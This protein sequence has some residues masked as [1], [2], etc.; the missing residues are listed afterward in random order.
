MPYSTRKSSSPQIVKSFFP[1]LF[2]H[3]NRSDRQER[4]GPTE[5]KTLRGFFFSVE[6]AIDSKWFYDDH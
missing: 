4:R 5:R 6:I 3:R 2:A 1:L